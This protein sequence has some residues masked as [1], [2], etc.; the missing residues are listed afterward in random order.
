MN[1][2]E[3]YKKETGLDAYD[4]FAFDDSVIMPTPEYIEWL[5]KTVSDVYKP[6]IITWIENMFEHAEKKQWY[7]TYWAYDIHG[8]ISRPDYRKKSKQIDYYPYAKETLEYISKRRP[9]IIM[10]LW[11]SSYPEELKIYQD[12]FIKDGINFKYSNEN[13]EIA[14]AKGSF[15]YYE[16]KF[17]YNVMF[18]DKSG[19]NPERDWKFIYDYF[20][21]TEYKPNPNWSMKY[22]EDYHE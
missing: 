15:G 20:T 6:Q 19:F 11:S 13:P 9:D 4:T 17:Y 7:E 16:Q 5:E 10:I 18:E 1:S 14:D 12:T 8:V 3:L 2:Q 21:T 22:K